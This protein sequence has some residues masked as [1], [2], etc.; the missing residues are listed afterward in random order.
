MK[1]KTS[2]GK[3][4]NINY[5]NAYYTKRKKNGNHSSKT[6]HSTEKKMYN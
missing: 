2:E 5:E 6:Y 1:M 4:F 3:L